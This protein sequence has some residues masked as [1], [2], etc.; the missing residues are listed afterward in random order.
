MPRRR[1]RRGDRGTGKGPLH[2]ESV[3]A[4]GLLVV[5]GQVENTRLVAMVGVRVGG[6]AAQ[7]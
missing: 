4:A 7:A 3:A 2:G 6:C 5:V 1:R